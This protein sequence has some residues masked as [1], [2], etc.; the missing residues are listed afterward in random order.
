VWLRPVGGF[1]TAGRDGDL[2]ISDGG[3][4]SDLSK[5]FLSSYLPFV[6]KMLV[7][8]LLFSHPAV[9]G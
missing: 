4:M 3:E 9:A 6:R 5:I 8:Y 1:R 2:R 7:V